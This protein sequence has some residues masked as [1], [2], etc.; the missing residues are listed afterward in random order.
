MPTSPAITASNVS[1]SS[2]HQ[3]LVVA[4]G[5]GLALL[6]VVALVAY[7]STVAFGD[8]SAWVTHTHTVIATL[9]GAARAGPRA[10]PQSPRSSAE[11]R[12]SR[13]ATPFTPAS[14][15]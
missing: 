6:F 11:R 10:C 4:L 15:R 12:E 8:A 3:K 14:P 9:V 5:G 1:S 2:I 13:R 7:R